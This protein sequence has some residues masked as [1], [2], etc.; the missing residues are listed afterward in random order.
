MGDFV[1]G[2]IKVVDNGDEVYQSPIQG[3]KKPQDEVVDLQGQAVKPTGPEARQA[4][5]E[6]GIK[7]LVGLRLSPASRYLEM[8]AQAKSY[9]AQGDTFQTQDRLQKARMAA[10][11]AKLTFKED[12]ASDILKTSLEKELSDLVT[13]A[14]KLA[15]AGEVLALQ[16]VFSAGREILSRLQVPFDQAKAKGYAFHQDLIS[17]LET[18]AYANAMPLMWERAEIA[19][20]QGQVQKTQDNILKVREYAQR[21]QLTISADQEKQLVEFERQAYEF[22]IDKD[23]AEAAAY[24]LQGD[25]AQTRGWISKARDAAVLAKKPLKC[26]QEARIAAMERTVLHNAPDFLLTQAEAKADLGDVDAVRDLVQ[27][28]KDARGDIK[29]VLDKAELARAEAAEQRALRLSVDLLLGKAT[30]AVAEVKKNGNLSKIRAF[31]AQARENA[32]L[33]KT[34]L[35]SAQETSVASILKQAYQ[36]AV[37]WRFAQATYSAGLGKVD[38]TIVPLNAARDLAK[39]GQVS[40]DEAAAT[41]LIESA[42]TQGIELEFKVAEGFAASGDAVNTYLHLDLV[43]DHARR[44]GQKVDEKRVTKI[45]KLLPAK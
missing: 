19:S 39:Q 43:R 14:K 40:F 26:K 21:G 2:P 32:A 9:A 15:D 20:Q 24:A 6:L 7:T 36:A 41:K 22:S 13:R 23:L 31:I 17:Q 25:V 29:E 27:K 37:D 35:S 45:V 18:K 5:K 8:L 28:A 34:S 3:S 16:D 4:L 11:E 44:L 42:L 12:K 1:L 30:S 10:A 38:D 33:A